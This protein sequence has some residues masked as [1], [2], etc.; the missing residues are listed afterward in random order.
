MISYLTFN[1]EQCHY[2]KNNNET[3]MK[4]VMREM[5]KTMMVDLNGEHNEINDNDENTE[6]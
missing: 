1:D 5:M 2:S 4:T 3:I 6:K